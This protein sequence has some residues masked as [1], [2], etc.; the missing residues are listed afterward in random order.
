MA[1]GGG[2]ECNKAWMYYG[3]MEHRRL[4]ALDWHPLQMKSTIKH[5]H[6]TQWPI[7]VCLFV[8]YYR[9]YYRTDTK[10]AKQLF[11]FSS[12]FETQTLN[13]EVNEQSDTTFQLSSYRDGNIK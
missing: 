3:G 11:I 9:F 13:H 1:E 6:H 4:I 7:V 2:R 5:N 12:A 8:F 10:S